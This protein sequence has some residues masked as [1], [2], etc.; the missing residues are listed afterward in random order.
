MSTV[1]ITGANRGIGLEFARQYVAD[2]WRVRACCRDPQG[3]RAL[4][5]LQ[6]ENPDAVSVHRLDVDDD[7]SVA[8]ARGEIDGPIDVLLNNA[9]VMEGRA[10]GLGSMDYDAFEKALKTNVLGPMRVTEAF[11]DNVRRGDDKKIVTVSSRMGSL[12]ETQPNAL[13]YRTSKAAVNMTMRCLALA[14]EGEG[15]INVVVHPGWVRTD[16]GGAGADLAPDESAAALR[17]VI[18]GLG[19]ANNGG[20]FNYD[21]TPIPW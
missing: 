14:P 18:A 21:G 13:I 12:T 20:F 2:G 19:P 8:Q 15:M 11:F 17:R 4:S 7:A 10:A 9:G 3:A 5:D 6:A 16:M 1:M